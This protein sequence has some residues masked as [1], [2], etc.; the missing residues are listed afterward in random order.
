MWYQIT[1]TSVHL[2]W[3]NINH[4]K[5]FKKDRDFKMSWKFLQSET[6]FF[7]S[8]REKKMLNFEN[9]AILQLR[10]GIL[11]ESLIWILKISVLGLY[12]SKCLTFSLEFSKI[13]RI[14][15][16]HVLENVDFSDRFMEKLL[17]SVR[18]RNY[19]I[20]NVES[21]NV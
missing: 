17:R 10:K 20:A 18:K 12:F 15:L 11:L 14:F 16:K 9:S 2:L 13:V 4:Q 5:L 1:E 19:E 21:L 3:L 8:Y 6:H 7:F